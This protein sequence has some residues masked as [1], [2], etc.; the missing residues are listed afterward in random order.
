MD[1][2]KQEGQ[3]SRSWAWALGRWRGTLLGGALPLPSHSECKL[4]AGCFS[5]LM[6]IYSLQAAAWGAGLRAIYLGLLGLVGGTQ[7]PSS[8]L[9]HGGNPSRRCKSRQTFLI[10]RSLA[11]LLA[12][13]PSPAFQKLAVAPLSPFTE[14]QAGLERT[15][16]PKG[17]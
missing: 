2:T 15:R 13:P 11:F 4:H 10:R 7:V 3:A 6:F 17:S 9:G 8:T 14:E 12:P 16:P 1:E 5:C